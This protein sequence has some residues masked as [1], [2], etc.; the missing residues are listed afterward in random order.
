MVS[1]ARMRLAVAEETWNNSR[2]WALVMIWFSFKNCRIFWER[3]S[4]AE[5]FSFGFSASSASVKASLIAESINKIKA[6]SDL[7]EEMRDTDILYWVGTMNAI[8]NQA[9]EIVFNELIYV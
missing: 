4:A 8:K 2:T 7:T 9:E 5:G 3:S 1:L 6:E